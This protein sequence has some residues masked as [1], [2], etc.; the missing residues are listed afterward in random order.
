MAFNIPLSYGHS[1]APVEAIVAQ[2]LFLLLW[3]MNMDTQSHSTT[4]MNSTIILLSAG[5]IRASLSPRA[6]LDAL[7][8][9]YAA[10]HRHPED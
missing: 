4:E 10:L 8:E 3:E 2:V 9:T 1:Q 5:D 7:Q 6:C